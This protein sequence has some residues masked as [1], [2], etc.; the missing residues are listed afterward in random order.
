MDDFEDDV[1]FTAAFE[2]IER[3]TQPAPTVSAQIPA[4]V[5]QPTPQV[6]PSR[7][8]GSSILVS[9]RQKG[10]PI[11]NSVKS[12]PWEYS[13]IPADFVLG[14]TT[15]ALFLSL[16]Y[17]RLHP[18]YIY[19]RIQ[20]LGHKYNLRVLLTMVDIQNHEEPLKELSKTSM[21]NNL[22]LI[23]C[24]SAQE[25]GRY[26]ELFKSYEHAS[27]NSIR[28]HQSTSYKD[29]LIEFVTIPRSINQ[30]DATSLISAFGTVKAAINARPEEVGMIPGWGEKK[31]QRWC[32]TVSEPFRVKKAAKRGVGLQ[33]G[34]S[35]M[36]LQKQDSLFVEAVDLAVRLD[37]DTNRN[38]TPPVISSVSGLGEDST[39]AMPDIE[40]QLPPKRLA[41]E[42]STWQPGEDEE[43][44]LSLATA[45]ETAAIPEVN[46]GYEREAQAPEG[47]LNAGMAAALARLRKG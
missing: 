14:V 8:S 46:N 2:A 10:N 23:L 11:L 37:D 21:V 6:L 28:A 42:I 35:S 19:N 39:K 29:K 31:T 43:E 26:L 1:D 3:K 5:Q 36:T 20:K 24:W 25:A 45:E 9:P 15:C 4:K 13:D 17:H 34:E 12:L 18:E 7:T 27:P 38:N 22:T 16:K 47:A 32:G 41:K 33:R 30:T 40:K 44:A